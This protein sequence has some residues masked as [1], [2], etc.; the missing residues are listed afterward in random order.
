MKDMND[1]YFVLNTELKN[2]FKKQTEDIYADFYL[3]YLPTN[4]EH[5][6]GFLILKD[7]PANPEYLIASKVRKDLSI[8]QNLRK[9]LDICRSLPILS[10]D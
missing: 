6:G 1:V 2:W 8:E 5:N 4:A 3:W 7:K 9:L 10:I